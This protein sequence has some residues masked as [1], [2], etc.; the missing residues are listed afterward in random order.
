MD[1]GTLL[2]YPTRVLDGDLPNRDFEHFYG[3][4]NL[5]LLASTYFF[6]GAS[7]TA[8]RS[9]GVV[10]RLLIVLAVFALARRSGALVAV[11]AG[12]IAAFILAAL[13]SSALAWLG[14]LA[15]ALSSLALATERL[16]THG[17]AR[18][19]AS[20]LS[21]GA[22]LLGGLSL[23]FRLDLALAVLLYSTALLP[24]ATSRAR[25]AR[26]LGFVAG[27]SPYA[28]H[29][30]LAGIRPVLD[31]LV[32]DPVTVQSSG[33]R[34]PIPPDDAAVAVL[35]YLVM[36]IVGCLL[37]WSIY[38]VRMRPAPRDAYRLLAIALFSAGLLPQMLQRDDVVHVLYVAC[39]PLAF[40][41][42]LLASIMRDRGSHWS[43]AAATV[44]VVFAVFLT[45]RA[46]DRSIGVGVFPSYA[47]TNEGRSF[48]LPSQADAHDVQLLLADVDRLAV[49]GQR[50]FVGPRDLRRTNYNDTYLYFLLP[51][52]TPATYFL[53][54]NPG[55]ANAAGSRLA[56]DI[57]SADLL[58]L[59]DAYDHWSEPNAS[60]DFGSTEPS[61]VVRDEF[62]EVATRSHW[63]LLTRC[64][65]P[66]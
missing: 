58:I 17:G 37:V 38:R 25:R 64:A 62:C 3:P 6:A 2:L 36:A 23:V 43:L 49:P 44:G 27:L 53:E 65:P 20:A 30:W 16:T 15:L 54:M 48:P 24:S 10:Y 19:D 39:V 40:L 18:N 11:A 32:I 57:R 34:L 22:G 63:A 52:L 26:L 56:G 13:G 9:V 50:L 29:V 33:R 60:R 47:V 7:V 61:D 4:G 41:P 66:Q 51:K 42:V 45:A 8:E 31:G 28:I 59:T 35:M 46:V 21:F 5:W 12:L 14:G 55:S 1:E